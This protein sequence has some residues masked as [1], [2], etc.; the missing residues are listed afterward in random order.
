MKITQSIPNLFNCR[1]ASKFCLLYHFVS[2]DN[3]LIKRFAT[4][5]CSK[6]QCWLKWNDNVVS[7][8]IQFF[9]SLSLSHFTEFYGFRINKDF[10]T[11]RNSIP[12]LIGSKFIRQNSLD[13]YNHEKEGNLIQSPK[14]SIIIWKLQFNV[15]M[16]VY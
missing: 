2:I 7:K 5:D 8:S 9:S 15:T 4:V 16:F 10:Q 12:N 11:R 14:F 6:F 13:S 1:Y 3:Y